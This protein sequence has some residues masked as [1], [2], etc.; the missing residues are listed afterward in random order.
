MSQ[1]VIFEESVGRLAAQADAAGRLAKDAGGFAA[2]VAAFEAKDADAFRWVLERQGLLTH[3]E[4]ICEW[5]RI[6]LCVLRCI[7]VCGPPIDVAAPT[8]PEF[9]HAVVQLAS[10]ETLLRRV[11]DSVACGN[12]E[13]FH[14][15]LAELKLERVCHLICHWVCMLIYRRVCEVIC[16]PQRLPLSDAASDIRAAAKVMSRVMANEKAFATIARAAMA[17]DCETAR[18]AIDQAGFVRECEII[19]WVI[20]SWRCAWVC[21]EL[22]RRP[23]PI[24]TGVEAIEEARSFALAAHQLASQPRA[25]GDLVQAILHRD[26]KAYGDI[27]ARFRLGPYCMQVCAWVCSITCA[28]FCICLCRNPALQPWFTTVGYFDITSDI[29][30]TSGKTNK[31]LPAPSLGAHGGPNFAFY[32]ALQLGG[33][34]PATSPVFSGI[35]MK[36]RFLYDNGSGTPKP[37]TGTLV[38][39]VEAGT[40]LVMWPQNVGGNA[41]AALVQTFQA[42]WI[43]PAPTP[44]DPVPPAAGAAYA[45]PSAHYITPDAD[46]WVTVDPDAIGGGF[47]VLLGFDTTP[48]VAGGDP[49]PGVLAGTAVPGAAQRA[50]TD[51]SITFQ[52]TRTTTLPPGTVPDYSNA[53]DKIHVNNWTEVNELNFLEFVMGSLGC[54]TPIDALLS[55][56]FTTDHEEMAAGAWSLGI[57]SCSVSAPGDITPHIS[58]PGVTVTSRGGSGT[59]VET[60]SGW[61]SCSYT[62]TLTTRPGLTT[63]L[64][65]RGAW[66]NPLT[67]CICGH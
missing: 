38:S 66:S 8:L 27:I 62:V 13:E 19:C 7:Q 49:H 17:L 6:K 15:A 28:E 57:S 23:V 48:V 42:V 22:C 61:L 52:A 53:L 18:T 32:G 5:V 64:V 24:L 63:G 20:C 54:C 59:I 56:Q 65:D 44:P 29:D 55:V 1:T 51:L 31:G 60:T 14:A 26:A 33:F 46:G 58:G 50:G 11:V 47:Q 37:V 39:P 34:C 21:L 16:S 67:F 40:R 4:L 36:Y 45:A 12:A 9:A 10:N 43:V 3:C 35:P 30:G 2:A 41:G 25:L